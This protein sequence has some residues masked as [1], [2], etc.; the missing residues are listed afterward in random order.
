MLY[1]GAAD[2]AAAQ[3]PQRSDSV[4]GA[5]ER[6]QPSGAAAG[7]SGEAV[8]APPADQEELRLCAELQAAKAK[9]HA[10]AEELKRLKQQCTALQSRAESLQSACEQSFRTWWPV[11]CEE[12]AMLPPSNAGSCEGS[13]AARSFG[14]KPPEEI[15]IFLRVC[16]GKKGAMSFHTALKAHGAFTM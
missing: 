15:E 14:G 11:A 8:G 10:L 9:Y 5:H 2:P 1:L 4:Y 12:R 16:S 13:I 3:P 6:A 7:S